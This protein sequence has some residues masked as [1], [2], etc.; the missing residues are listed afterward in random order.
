[1][2]GQGEL[3]C[4]GRTG[5]VALCSHEDLSWHRLKK[6]LY[7]E[8]TA[9]CTHHTHY[10]EVHSEVNAFGSP[11]PRLRLGDIHFHLTL[12]WDLPLLQIDLEHR[13]TLGGIRKKLVEILSNDNIF[14]DHRPYRHMR[15]GKQIRSFIRRTVCEC[16]RKSGSAMEYTS[17]KIK[18]CSCTRQLHL[19]CAECG[20][21][22]ALFLVGGCLTLS[23]RFAWNIWKPTS[24]AWVGMLDGVLEI[25]GV[26]KE[27]NK[28]FLWCDSP[29]CWTGTEGRRWEDLLKEETW[30][31]HMRYGQGCDRPDKNESRDFD[32]LNS[33]HSYV[34]PDYR[35]PEHTK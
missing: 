20:A 31:H 15:D 3:I 25:A 14:R 19:D 34:Q 1:M 12:G 21:A 2:R 27:E 22:Y 30:L 17:N 11:A 9:M 26:L 23:Y 8:K 35:M 18:E 13:P 24:P 6:D 4:I 7:N 32:E 28:H 33:R 16:F 10:R 5:K 29:G